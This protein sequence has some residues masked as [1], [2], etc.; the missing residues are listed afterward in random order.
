MAS[1]K[2]CSLFFLLVTSQD[3]YV[4]FE[5]TEKHRNS[6]KMHKIIAQLVEKKKS[7]SL[8]D[9]KFKKKT[10]LRQNIITFIRIEQGTGVSNV[11]FME[12]V[13]KSLMITEGLGLHISFERYSTSSGGNE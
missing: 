9:Y 11:N 3:F 2:K 7:F 13:M 8:G 12:S 10:E 5:V 1:L 6:L 4:K